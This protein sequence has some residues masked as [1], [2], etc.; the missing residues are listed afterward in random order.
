MPTNRH[1]FVLTETDELAGALELAAHRWPE[2]ADSRSR[3]LR[4]LVQAGG[5]ALNAEQEQARARRRQAVAR[6]HGQF[7]DVYGPD[8]LKRLRDEWPA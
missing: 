6:T 7:R 3:L 5:H 4:R 2:D 8:Y 1:R